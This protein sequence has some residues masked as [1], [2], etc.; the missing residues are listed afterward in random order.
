MG[1]ARPCFFIWLWPWP[2]IFFAIPSAQLI[3][4]NQFFVQDVNHNGFAFIY[5]SAK[6]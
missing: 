4:E 2:V 5:R 1:E 6:D 3:P